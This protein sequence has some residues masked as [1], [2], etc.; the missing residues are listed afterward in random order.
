MDSQGSLVVAF[1]MTCH[2][3]DFVVGE[4][5][6]D[7]SSAILEV[8]SFS[9]QEQPRLVVPS[10]VDSFA[11]N[12]SHLVRFASFVDLLGEIRQQTR[13][14]VDSFWES[15]KESRPVLYTLVAQAF[16]YEEVKK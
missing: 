13:L 9:V 6:V 3:D 2:N 5:G 1:E 14:G 15:H 16:Y 7:N 12:Q 8:D 10:F 11:E 4:K